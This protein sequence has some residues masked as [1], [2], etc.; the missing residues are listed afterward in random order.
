MAW[1]QAT[2]D[3]LKSKDKT[4]TRAEN[5]LTLRVEPTG[6]IT[7]YAYLN[8]KPYKLGRHPI[9][10]LKN[11]KKKKDELYVD[12]YMG[13]LQESKLTFQEFVNSSK[14]QDWSMGRKTHKARMASMKATI[15]PILGKY[16]LADV[17]STHITQYKNKRKALEIQESTI[18]RELN[19]IGS[20]LTQAQ[21]MKLIRERIKI[22]KF[23]EDKTKEKRILE[24]WEVK[25]LR[26]ASRN[27]KGLNQRLKNQRRHIR[28]VIDIGYWCGLRKGE[29]LSLTWRDVVRKGHFHKEF[30]RDSG[31]VEDWAEDEWV[32]GFTDSRS[33]DYALR[34]VGSRTKT[35]QSRL[36]PIGKELLKELKDYYQWFLYTNEKALEEWDIW[37]DDVKEGKVKTQGGEIAIASAHLDL[38]LFPYSN[39]DN[40]FNTTRNKARLDKDITLHS[41]RHNFCTKS[42]EAGM[43]LHCVKELAGHA[44]IETTELYLH[45]N[46]KIKFEQYQMAESYLS[47]ETK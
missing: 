19:D 13:R 27:N 46:P 21:I 8:R 44:S 37:M 41:L 7:Y 5:N 16:K 39:V 47:R 14:F 11:A 10:S 30:L 36:V 1:T 9:L 31:I 18:N 42:L 33:R 40:S 22:K 29:I 24:D 15:L 45:A 25:A 3:H 4:Y 23:K 34:I 32:K 38:D 6:T 12:K 28:T 26:E 2:I 35:G 43:S 17:D 20:V